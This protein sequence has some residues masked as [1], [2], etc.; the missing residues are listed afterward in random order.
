[1]NR[2]L[3][4]FA[5]FLSLTRRDKFLPLVL[6]MWLTLICAFDAAAQSQALDGQIEGTVS[7]QNNSVITNAV[8]TVTNADTGATRTVMTDD[9]GVYR[10]PLLS[11]GNLRHRRQTRES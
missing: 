1:M 9:S 7:D 10:F 4:K 5:P 2:N 8:I 3:L 11:L 6:A